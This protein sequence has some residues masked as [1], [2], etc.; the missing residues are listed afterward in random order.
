[1]E[2]IYEHLDEVTPAKLQALLREN[3]AIARQSKVLTTIVT[4]APVTLN[5]QETHASHFNRNRV[6]DIFRELE[7]S[8]LLNKLPEAAESTSENKTVATTAHHATISYRLVNTTQAL[9]SLVARL[10]ETKTFAFDTETTGLRPM[11]AQ[12]VGISI[13]P[14]TGESY[15]IP[16]GHVGMMQSPQLPLEQVVAKLKPIFYDANKSKLAHNGKFDMEVLAEVGIIVTNLASDTM[17]AAYLLSEP[18]LGLKALAFGRLGIEMAPISTLIGTGSKQIPMSQVE[19]EKA[20]DYSCADADMT[21]RLNEVLSKEL[22]SQE[23]WRLF[24]EVEMPLVPFY[25]RWKKMELRW[26]QIF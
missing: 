10:S 24:D 3:E 21:G 1:V 7:F 26:I 13:S 20:T 2:Q 12:L 14:A 11:L 25:L 22:K 8:S 19:I 5:L 6:A 18:S 4:K 15:Y 16:V 23:L 17:I 9:D